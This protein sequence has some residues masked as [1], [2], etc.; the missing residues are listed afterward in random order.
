MNTTRDTGIR[1][2]RPSW[3]WSSRLSPF[4]DE[5]YLVVE[6]SRDDRE[7]GEGV[8]VMKGTALLIAV[9]MI[10]G[11]VFFSFR[12]TPEGMSFALIDTCC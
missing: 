2:R 8:G 11:L 7:S 9:S 6:V 4:D 3:N 1:M 5:G 10:S 12:R